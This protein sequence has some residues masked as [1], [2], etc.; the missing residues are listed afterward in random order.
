MARQGAKGVDWPAIEREYVRSPEGIAYPALAKKHGLHPGT[1]T[2]HGR[3]G[4]WVA[5]RAEYHE[6]ATRKA[7]G[8]ALE[9]EAEQQADQIVDTRA[10]LLET[11]CVLLE[12]IQSGSLEANSLDA[13]A[14]ALVNI[15]KFLEVLGGNPDSRTEQ[16]VSI[17]PLDPAEIKRLK[18]LVYAL[19]DG[20]G[21]GP[22]DGGGGSSGEGAE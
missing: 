12:R 17:R 19:D 3:R 7:L 2:E 15:A 10:G 4:R 6:E 14:N 5:K 18:E 13:A 9:K 21:T 1:V 22:G 16:S 20:D 8:K 11:F